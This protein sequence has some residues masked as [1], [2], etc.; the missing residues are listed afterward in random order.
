MHRAQLVVVLAGGAPVDQFVP[1][2]VAE[3]DVRLAADS[4][5]DLAERIGLQVDQ[6][7]GDLD[8]VSAAALQRARDRGTAITQ[9][10]PDKDETDLELT[11]VEAMAHV[12][13][14]RGDEIVVLGGAGGRL[15]H[16][17]A[18]HAVLTSARWKHAAITAYIGTS[19][20]D[21]VHGDVIRGAGARHARSLAGAPNCTV[22]LLA[23][24]GAARGV[25]TGGL[26]WPLHDATIEAG[27]AYGTSN[28][29][30]AR[31]ATVSLESGTLTATTDGV[32]ST[33]EA[34]T[35]EAGTVVR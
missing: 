35:V 23:W 1:A 19:R 12:I 2:R 11:F 24:H 33:V 5:L 13:A 25:T 16:L 27:S 8:S 17:L 15:D 4:G 31:V 30:L 9:Y 3:A 14:D 10:P 7:I 32:D 21:V 28:E 22:S 26:R 6:V 20:V 29:Y 34:G 18:N